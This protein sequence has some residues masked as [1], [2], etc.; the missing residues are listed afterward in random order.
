MHRTDSYESS[1]SPSLYRTTAEPGTKA[2]DLDKETFPEMAFNLL[3]RMGWCSGDIF[4]YLP[5][6]WIAYY[7]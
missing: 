1:C 7:K 5:D 6:Y 4:V 2:I 3:C